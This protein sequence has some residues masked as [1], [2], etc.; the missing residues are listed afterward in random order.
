MKI[1][2]SIFALALLAFFTA[3]AQVTVE[4]ALDQDQFLPSESLP[5]YVKITNR[6]GQPLHLG[7]DA[8]WLTFDV[9]SVDSPIV[10]K[11]GD[12]PVLGEF[13]VESSQVATKR[14]DLQP[15]FVLT[16]PGLYHVT[17]TVR[18]KD[19]NAE[20]TS[21]RQSLDVISGAKLWS[22]EFGVP[23]PAGVTNQPPEVRKYTLE[24]ANYLHSQLRMYVVVTDAS[25]SQVFKVSAV[26]P[27]VSFS[28]PEAQLDRYSNLHVI[29]Q[30]G[31]KSFTY[32]VVNPNGEIARQEIYDYFDT[33]P[34]LGMSDDGI[35]VTGGVRRVKAGELPEVKSPLELPPAKP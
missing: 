15:Y 30:S 7:A 20:I 9:E 25:E 19:W 12:A 21:S 22:Q 34:H 1:S 17:A 10:F 5:V 31:S 24:E 11:N 35:V 14:V 27:M 23:A 3:S 28:Q 29:Y 6:S 18:I 16:R 33:R 2:L 26:G 32:T 4:V 8:N 13:T